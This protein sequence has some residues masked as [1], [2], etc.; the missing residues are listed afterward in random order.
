M[1]PDPQHW[2]T[3]YDKI[4]VE[5]VFTQ[6]AD[7]P[8]AILRFPAI[9]G[10]K[11]YRRFHRWLQPMLRGDAELPVQDAWAR[12][13]WTHGFA[14]DVAEAVILTAT[15]SRS[16]GR[17][18]NVGESHTPT[19]AERLAEFARVAGWRGQ[20]PEVPASELGE[21]DRMPYDFANHIAYDTTRIRAELGYKEVVPLG[22]ALARTLE[23]ER[24]PET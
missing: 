23:Y 7:L 3:Q 18:Y 5:R 24:T 13:R 19:M 16:A 21:T 20:I 1:A 11:E 14:E 12:W 9:L 6:Q 17:I 10:P 15:N 2:M 4:L 8:T 22:I